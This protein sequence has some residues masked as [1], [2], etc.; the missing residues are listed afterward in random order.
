MS[1]IILSGERAQSKQEQR[2]GRFMPGKGRAINCSGA[3]RPKPCQKANHSK[4]PGFFSTTPP[5]CEPQFP[6]LSQDTVHWPPAARSTHRHPAYQSP[7]TSR[8]AH[9]FLHR[10]FAGGSVPAQRALPPGVPPQNFQVPGLAAGWQEAPGWQSPVMAPAPNPSLLPGSATPPRCRL[11]KHPTTNEMPALPSTK[12]HTAYTPKHP[13]AQ[14]FPTP[15]KLPR[16]L[17]RKGQRVGRKKQLRGRFQEDSG[18]LG[19]STVRSSPTGS[20]TRDR[21][22]AAAPG[23]AAP[24]QRQRHQGASDHFQG[25]KHQTPVLP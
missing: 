8:S 25:C 9:S 3:G 2:A 22:W 13:T 16:K 12:G 10:N 20:S 21:A 4:Q 23:K 18:K 7:D 11:S 1:P 6:A 5:S 15:G 19:L 24:P 14:G 17:Q